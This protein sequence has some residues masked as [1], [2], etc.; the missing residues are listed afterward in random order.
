MRSRPRFLASIRAKLEF[1]MSTSLA[2][3]GMFQGGAVDVAEEA[4]TKFASSIVNEA[5]MHR[6]L[7]I[8]QIAHGGCV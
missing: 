5:R 8:R 1:T 4:R 6:G 7:D 3:A 2:S